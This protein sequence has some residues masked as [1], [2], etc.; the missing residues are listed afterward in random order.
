MDLVSSDESAGE[1]EEEVQV[2]VASTAPAPLQRFHL[3]FSQPLVQLRSYMHPDR[4]SLSAGEAARVASV[5]SRHPSRDAAPTDPAAP[6]PAPATSPGGK[7]KGKGKQAAAATQAQAAAISWQDVAGRWMRDSVSYEGMTKLQRGGWLA[8]EHINFCMARW[9]SL[10]R[11]AVTATSASTAGSA[12]ASSGSGPLFDAA[13]GR[14]LGRVWATTSFFYRALTGDT[15]GNNSSSGS[16]AA[17]GSSGYHYDAVVRWTRRASIAVPVPASSSSGSSSGYV[18]VSGVDVAGGEVDG[19]LVPIHTGV[20]W[21]IAALDLRAQQAHMYDSMVMQEL[22]PAYARMLSTL[23]QWVADEVRHNSHS[24][25]SGSGR[26]VDTAAWTFHVHGLDGAAAAGPPQQ[27]NDID[28]GLFAIHYARC[29]AAGAPFDFSQHDM[30]ALR[31]AL[32]RDIL[33][34]RQR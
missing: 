24:S 34:T 13:G 4:L 7:G 25:G 26:K 20:H 11:A 1:G 21:A 18:E 5:L 28:C 32:A 31:T 3:D 2:Q 23:V 16:G 22:Q 17:S 29:L 8:S 6:A 14:R 27:D 19:V 15:H 12:S 10:N 30:P 9:N 33:R